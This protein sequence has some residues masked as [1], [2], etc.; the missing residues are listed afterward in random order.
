MYR[1]DWHK[2]LF[3]LTVISYCEWINCASDLLI[4]LLQ[5]FFFFSFFFKPEPAFPNSM[6]LGAYMSVFMSLDG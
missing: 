1:S 4:S 6:N 2:Y 5:A 3:C